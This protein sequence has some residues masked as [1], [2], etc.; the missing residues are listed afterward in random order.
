MKQIKIIIIIKL[1]NVKV[2]NILIKKIPKK[3]LQKWIFKFKKMKYNL[4]IYNPPMKFKDKIQIIMK[5]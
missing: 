1:K 4:I 5:I 2:N 3:L